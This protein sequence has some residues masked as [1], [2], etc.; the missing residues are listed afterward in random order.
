MIQLSKSDFLQVKRLLSFLA[1][2]RL[3]DIKSRE[4]SRQAAL[5]LKKLERR[6]ASDESN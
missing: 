4:K 5:L 3:S 6:Q 2:Q 1:G